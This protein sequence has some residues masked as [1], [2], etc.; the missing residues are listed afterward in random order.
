MS[1]A[2]AEAIVRY[3]TGNGVNRD[4]LTPVGKGEIR[5]I[6]D[7][8]TEQGRIANRRVELLTLPGRDIVPRHVTAVT[9]AAEVYLLNSR[10]ATGK[11]SKPGPKPKSVAKTDDAAAAA[12]E[13]AI[14]AAHDAPEKISVLPRALSLPGTSLNGVQEN[15]DFDG[16]ST[17]LSTT[18]LAALD[19]IVAQLQQHPSARIAIMAH[20]DLSLIHI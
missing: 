15:I 5:P 19:V 3:L 13:P 2:R 20:T 9:P 8:D 4:E 6:A 1:Q 16:R 18:S 10:K 11:A 12:E 7:N 17:D 14:Q